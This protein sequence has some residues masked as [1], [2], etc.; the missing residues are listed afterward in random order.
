[1]EAL[2]QYREK[3]GIPAKMVV[4]GMVSNG[5]TIADPEDAGSMDVVGFDSA[6]PELLA[7]FV[8]G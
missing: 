8:Q 4:I 5:F 7:D 6:V 2:R 1:M 3:T